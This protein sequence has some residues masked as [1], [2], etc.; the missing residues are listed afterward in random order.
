MC[1]NA[2]GQKDTLY[3]GS[4]QFSSNFTW[5]RNYSCLKLKQENRRGLKSSMYTKAMP[6]VSLKLRGNR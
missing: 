5:L 3:I 4:Q 1:I 6:G 2:P